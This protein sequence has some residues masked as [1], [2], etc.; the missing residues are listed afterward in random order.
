MKQRLFTTNWNQNFV[1]KKLPVMIRHLNP[2]KEDKP[3]CFNYYVIIV[4]KLDVIIIEDKQKEEL[5]GCPW[6][7]ERSKLQHQLA[8]FKLH[9]A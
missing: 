7:L 1:Q 6:T 8:L 2:T 4:T 5:F 9:F 3:N